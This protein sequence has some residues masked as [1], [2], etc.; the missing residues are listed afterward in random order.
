MYLGST[1]PNGGRTIDCN[2][3]SV[4]PKPMRLGNIHVYNNIIDSTWR[5]G[6]QLSDAD[7]GYNEINNN[8]IT[9]SGFEFNG[10]QGNGIIIG[11]Y[12][13]ADIHDNYVRNT[14]GAGIFSLGAG[15]IKIYNNDVDS[16]GYLGGK[17]KGSSNIMVDTR[18]TNFPSPSQHNPVLT[19]FSIWN[20]NLGL[21]TDYSIRVFKTFDTFLPGNI[22]CNNTGNIM[23][24]DGVD[25][26]KD[27]NKLKR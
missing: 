20:N 21:N 25:W 27:C 15:I 11:G 23:V 10:E 1:D 9:N 12:T 4:A 14:F 7:S 3:K 6:I 2:G 18:P 22:I 24:A 26:S 16:S 13:H 5:G 17:G 8:T 19:K